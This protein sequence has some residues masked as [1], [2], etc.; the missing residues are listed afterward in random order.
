MELSKR[1]TY[2]RIIFSAGIILLAA[3][4]GLFLY[5]TYQENMSSRVVQSSNMVSHHLESAYSTLQEKEAALRGSLLVNDTALIRLTPY[6]QRLDSLLQVTEPLLQGNESQLKKLAEL[7]TLTDQILQKDSILIQHAGSRADV[8][9]N[10]LVMEKLRLLINQMQQLELQQAHALDIEAQ[11]HTIF[12]TLIGVAAS[13]F[14][15]IVFVLAF[16][17]I[18]QELKRTQML[19][20][21][22]RM[23]NEKVAQFNTE[24]EVANKNLQ[25]LNSE[26]GTKNVQLEKYAQ[27]ISSFTH[28]TSHDMQEPLRK[29]E[30]FISV[31]EDR[32]KE[33]LS[34]E[35]KRLLDKVVQSVLR[36]RKL[37]LSM[38]EFSMTNTVGNVVEVI[39]LN[40][41][42]NLTLESLKVYIK[43]NN[44][45]IESELLP[46]VKGIKYQYI[47]LFE[48]IIS[49]AIKFKRKGTTPELVIG[50]VTINSDSA[51]HLGLKPSTEYHR[52]DFR[53]NGIGFDRVYAERIFQIF[54][55]LVPANESYSVGIGLT[56][57][58]KIAENH[59]GILIA[60][61]ELNVGSVFS[62]FIPVDLVPSLAVEQAR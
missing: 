51:S 34:D 32:E 24:L 58:R 7:R 40:E 48:N 15:I 56:I 54:Q 49:N 13:M 36:M 62:L 4:C 29:I 18:D 50:C 27:E 33:H 47:Q 35:G 17:F 9:K 60:D 20:N 5:E 53:D 45:I 21:E 39:D 57:A 10:G 38:L 28:I 30:F 44:A 11:K 41:V 1:I 61:S 22:T 25:Q 14:S 31:I 23:L 6:R 52:I 37:F 8:F 12:A 2:S 59:G 3:L 42:L 46:R 26:L 16:Y 43:D 55:R 19:V